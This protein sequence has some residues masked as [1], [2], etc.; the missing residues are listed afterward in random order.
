VSPASLDDGQLRLLI[1]G[2]EA[3]EGE[4]EKERME[5]IRGIVEGLG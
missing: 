1:D 2:Y 3:L 4:S 5:R